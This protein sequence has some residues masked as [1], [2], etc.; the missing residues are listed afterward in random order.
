MT[1]R[2]QIGSSSD[3][4]ISVA[5]VPQQSLVTILLSQD[6]LG[7]IRQLKISMLKAMDGRAVPS[8][9][10]FAG[11]LPFVSPDIVL[12][13]LPPLADL[14]TPQQVRYLLDAPATVLGDDLMRNF[15][16]DLPPIWRAIATDPT[17]WL[18]S[19]A[20]TSLFCWGVLEPYWKLAQPM[21]DR[22]IMRVG[23]ALTRG[24]VDVLLNSLHSRI[25]YSH[26]TIS[27]GNGSGSVRCL[28]NRKLV[29]V[30]MV[31]GAN[32]TTVTFDHPEVAFI[33]YPIPGIIP[34]L[35]SPTH[36]AEHTDPLAVLL[37]LPK[38]TILRYLGS[39]T[40]MGILAA[41]I[42]CTAATAKFHCDRLSDAGLISRTRRGRTVWVSRSSRGD[43]LVA[44]FSR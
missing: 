13:P 18:R 25:S 17:K 23:V 32:A 43:E 6:S 44:L 35:S 36:P 38:S 27:V 31:A 10:T 34:A 12:S 5:R 4:P 41:A 28:G 3:R 8:L 42:N 22:E 14:T 16:E 29:L 21:I 7:F 19:Y 11:T 24:G 2:L 20:Y 40:S 30:P 9:S 39:A 37:G 15:G 33:G 1:L 26:G